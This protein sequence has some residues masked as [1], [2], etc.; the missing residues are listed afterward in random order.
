VEQDPVHV[1]LGAVLVDDKGRV[2]SGSVPLQVR[3]IDPFG[4]TRYD[5]HR[6]TDRGTLKIKLPLAAN[7][8]AG[9][10]KFVVRDLLVGTED[11]T[12]FAYRSP[13]QCGALLGLSDRAVYFGNDRQNIFRFFRTHQD[14]TVVTGSSAFNTAAAQRIAQMLKP[15]NVRC[16]IVTAAEVNRPREITAEEAPTWIGL[17]P[18][19]AKVGRDNPVSLVGFD[20]RGAVI[21]LG[22]PEDNPLI[23][24]LHRSGF[25]PYK[26]NKA[27]FPGRGRGMLAWQRDGVGYEQESVTLIAH[28]ETGMAETVGSLYQAAAGLDPLAR[29]VLPSTSAVTAVTKA[30]ARVPE[31]AEAWTATLPDRAAALKTLPGGKLIALTE[32]GSLTALD[33]QGRTLWQKAITGGEVWRL[34]ASADANL[35]VVGASQHLVAFDGK[36]NQIFDTPLTTDSSRSVVTFVTVAPDGTLIA[37]GTDRGQLTL[38]RADGKRLWVIGGV[39]GNDPKVKPNPYVAGSFANGS[40]ALLALTGNEAHVI[41]VTN[42]AVTARCGGVNG[43]FA[44]QTAGANLL[45]ADARSVSILAADGKVVRKLAVPDIGLAAALPI[46]DDILTGTE[47]DG[48]VRRL[49]VAADGKDQV[50]WEHKYAGHVVK[51]LMA[52]GERIAVGYWGGFVEVLDS[53]GAVQATRTF[54]QDIA[55]LAW[56]GD[57]LVACLAD[58]R[59]VAL[60][61]QKGAR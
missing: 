15:W 14:V 39:P 46:G 54:S 57:Q 17:E 30:P 49:R 36:G 21:L 27:T 5:L 19:K 41:N 7:D 9:E 2:L 13:A 4:V 59:V 60:S 28:D 23:E 1:D 42:G 22:T 33:T 11:T 25:L 53:Q 51:K 61:A 47:I 32:D 10:W 31:L 24:F 56:L 45:V 35:V 8:P 55:G 48:A 26:P 20:V 50:T 38:L 18:G 40:K 37:A 34:D 29:W 52:G 44:P 16:K 12:R 58:G 3:L 43:Q 6:A